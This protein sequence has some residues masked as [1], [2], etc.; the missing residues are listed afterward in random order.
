MKKI[1]LLLAFVII[2]TVTSCVS[3]NKKTVTVTVIDDISVTQDGQ[4][5]IELTGEVQVPVES[6]AGECIR[7]LCNLNEVTVIGID[8]GFVT[9]VADIK[10]EGN[11]AW[12]FYINGSLSETEGISDYIPEDGD[13]IELRYIDFSDIFAVYE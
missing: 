8:D 2:L 11:F 7:R 6:S 13:E 9:E 4:N 1:A 10:N 5:K 3:G 12:M